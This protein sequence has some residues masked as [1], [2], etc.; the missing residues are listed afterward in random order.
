MGTGLT[1]M[2]MDRGPRMQMTAAM[3]A[4]R[5]ICLVVK[6]RLEAPVLFELEIIFLSDK[7]I[8][9]SFPSGSPFSQGN[10]LPIWQDS[11]M[12]RFQGMMRKNIRLIDYIVIIT[13]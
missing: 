12:I 3:M 6:V 10:Y 8:M 7:S 1:G 5:V 4:E 13:I 9:Y 2:G 11:C